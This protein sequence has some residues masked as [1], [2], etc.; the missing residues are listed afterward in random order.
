MNWQL[1]ANIELLESDYSAKEI[2]EILG[3]S[4]VVVYP[5]RKALRD[6]K[7][8]EGKPADPAPVT[9]KLPPGTYTD[10]EEEVP[11][12]VTKLKPVPKPLPAPE[13]QKVN[14]V[15]PKVEGRITNGPLTIH[16]TITFQ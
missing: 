3:I 10:T 11:K 4:T 7:A 2:A 8:K 12:L 15:I 5:A 1:P 9:E 6:K 16:I 13:E 14:V